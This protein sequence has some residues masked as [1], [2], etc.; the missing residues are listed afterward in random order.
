MA[1]EE[2][3]NILMVDDEPAKLLTYDVILSSLGE[4][5]I[6]ATSARKALNILLNTDIA[7]VLMDVSM[8]DMD[9]FELANVIRQHPRFQKTA[10]IFISGV[11]LTDTDRILGYRRGAVD[12]I[13]VPVIPEVLRAKVSVFVELHRKTRQLEKLNSDLEQL[14]RARTDALRSSE[15]QF[16][17]RAELLELASEAI[18]ERDLSGEIRFW[19]AGAENLYGWRREQALGRDLHDLLK[20]VFPVSRRNMEEALQNTGSWQGNLLQTTQDGREIV[21]AF[22]KI[23][24]RETNAVLDVG[25]DITSQLRA[26][27]VLRESEKLAAMGRFAGII[28]H[29]INNPLAA[30]TNVFY[31]LR[32]HPSLDEDARRFAKMADQELQRISHI[33]KQTLSFYRESKRPVPVLL[34]E[35]VDDVLDLHTR[36][37]Q[38]LHITV[39]RRYSSISLLQGFP[40]ELKQVIMNLISNAVHALSGG[41][42]LR[43][44]VF[45]ATDWTTNRQGSTLCI[46]DTGVG[47]QPE[48]ALHIFEPFYTT[49]SSKGTGLGLWISR[50]IVQKYGGQITF[51]CYRHSGRAIT[52]FRVFIPSAAP[53]SGHPG[54]VDEAGN[55]ARERLQE[56]P[57]EDLPNP[58]SLAEP[59][60]PDNS[61][62]GSTDLLAHTMIDAALG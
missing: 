30:I 49:K 19:N 24:N 48:E 38:N 44:R 6:H 51:R 41:G 54:R 25:R 18:I 27:E 32:E 31:L 29:E 55:P 47:I 53:A 2:K 45:T 3:L 22:R 46:T 60:P 17:K 23:L 57:K 37:M 62:P 58:A 1:V 15:T 7:L 9:G 10:I 59:T 35:L 26:E 28:A 20:T 16:R 33:T 8:P 61:V 11:H 40:V 12:Y 39:L 36:P 50:G 42:Q 34:H 52:C 21:V 13:S 14:V 43:V 56:R 5:L 4:N